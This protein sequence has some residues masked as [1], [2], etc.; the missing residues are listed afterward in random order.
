MELRPYQQA[1]LERV[2]ARLW[3]G[4]NRQ[5]LK[6]PTG[7]GK[8]VCFA[9]LPD[10]LAFK[11][12]MLVLVHREEL[13]AQAADKLRKWNPTR[14]VGIEMGD[15][16][17]GDGDQ[18]V[19]ASVQTIGRPNAP[20]LKRFNA[21]EFDAV[22][23]DE[24]HHATA[25]SYGRVFEHFRLFEDRHRLALG[26]TA[27]SRRADGLALGRV[28]QE[29]V[30]D[31][32]LADGIRQG[33]LA[34]LHAYAMHTQTDL[35]A[36]R[37]KGEDFDVPELG[38]AVNTPA[39]ND[40]V[41]RNWL[42]H[43]RDLQTIV[44]GVDVQHAKSLAARFVNEG[45]AAEA[46]WG[47][48]PERV[49]K[50]K[51]H[52]GGR[53]TVLVNCQI[54]T[55]GYDDWQVQC[56]V[57]ARPTRSESLYVQMIGRG[58]RIPNDIDNLL[59]AQSRGQTIAKRHCS[60]LDFVDLTTKHSLM[61]LPTLLGLNPDIDLSGRSAVAVM[62][63]VKDLRDAR[64]A[65]DVTAVTS[66]E[67][68]AGWSE[69]VELFQVGFGQDPLRISKYDWRRSK[70]AYVLLL[71]A[72]R[73]IVVL[74]GKDLAWHVVGS[75]DEAE[76][77]RS[78]KTFDAAIRDGD[79]FANEHRARPKITLSTLPRWGQGPPTK[80]QRM[81]CGWNGIAIPDGATEAEAAL[82]LNAAIGRR[83]EQQ[84]LKRQGPQVTD[85]SE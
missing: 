65:V 18:L 17:A 75:V 55:E 32:S 48:D 74:C 70:N 66:I 9:A 53:T 33:W 49:E 22:V 80:S 52:K 42:S 38:K 67:Q 30:F 24:A 20:R 21:D 29:V 10:F 58:T 56:I 59:E 28:F 71:E 79:R 3:I 27:T 63:H 35:D 19:V 41:V 46:I 5:L 60:V 13:A 54:L 84:R 45:V 8:T 25:R 62:D 73:H 31:Y 72:D 40:F 12:R 2:R 4:V 15:Q 16:S 7:M 83:Q 77:E 36:V 47:D 82:V 44:F 11:N 37:A 68:L 69:H 78:W 61:T 76:I 81:M 50:L 26:V 57:L 6:L 14:R 39:R 85:Q 51:R 43:A 34:D 64:G 23:V 1:A